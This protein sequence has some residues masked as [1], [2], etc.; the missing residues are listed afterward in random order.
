MY[1][2][3]NK[4]PSLRY[5]VST[6]LYLNGWRL[7]SFWGKNDYLYTQLIDLVFKMVEV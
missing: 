5:I 2:S 6:D 4:Q 3:Y 7:Y 1:N